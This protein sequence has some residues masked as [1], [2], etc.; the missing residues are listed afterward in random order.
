MALFALGI[1]LAAVAPAASGSPPLP[2]G[3]TIYVVQPDPRLCPS[4][5]CGGYWVARANHS[6]TRCHDGLFRPRC[7]VARAVAWPRGGSLPRGVPADGLA[8]AF[9]GYEEIDGVGRL[10]VLIVAEAWKPASQAPAIG[11]YFR[12]RDTGV[13][14]IRAPCFSFRAWRVNR[15]YSVTVSD[16]DLS[17]SGADPASLRRAEAALGSTEGM[18]AAG[19]VS[20][21]PEGG[22]ILV[23]SQV[24][25]REPPPRA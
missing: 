16:L 25:L 21:T 1:A 3:R 22:R 11:S 7:Y 6:R 17:A 10:G 9:L 14:C 18:L 15:A 12:I 19:S 24:F 2:L 13:R 23:A 20:R 5:L 4:P 8:K